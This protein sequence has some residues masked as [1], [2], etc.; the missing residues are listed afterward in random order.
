[1][2]RGRLGLRLSL[3][4][5]VVFVVSMVV[6]V[7]ITYWL[8]ASSLARR[9]HDIIA[10]TLREYAL[11]YESDGL[12]ALERA[13]E[14]EQRTGSRERLFVRVLGRGADALFVSMPPGWSD[15]DIDRLGADDQGVER[16][17]A[18]SRDAVLE[19]ASA[20]L[21][22]GTIL[23]VGK[24]N[25][26]RVALLSQFR[27]VVGWAAVLAMFVGVMGGLLITRSTLQPPRQGCARWQRPSRGPNS[28]RC[29]DRP[30]WRG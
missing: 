29:R 27:T 23:Q 20:R 24:S 6:L 17:P 8:L 5:A 30:A 12:P 14:V 15:F 18:R 13:V 2:V 22:D 19:V 1:M 10:A 9:D 3:W 7:G 21:V 28:I 25:E 26:I 16:A 11:R 4:Y